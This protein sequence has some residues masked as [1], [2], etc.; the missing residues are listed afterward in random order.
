MFIYILK[1]G[2]NA[3]N[4]DV[5]AICAEVASVHFVKITDVV[6]VKVLEEAK[7][8]ILTAKKKVSFIGL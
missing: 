6:L 4:A 2:F 1:Q 3:F 7:S 5:F 8:K